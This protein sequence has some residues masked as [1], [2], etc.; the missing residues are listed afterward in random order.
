MPWI[1]K[2]VEVGSVYVE[3]ELDD[4]DIEDLFQKL[5]EEDQERILRRLGATFVAEGD[6]ARRKHL[7]A[8]AYSTIK[9]IGDVPR[10][11]QDFFY[12]VHGIAM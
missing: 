10:E 2:E 9:A 3:I 8:V 12:E 6:D 1:N 4:E 5:D 7:T 11:V